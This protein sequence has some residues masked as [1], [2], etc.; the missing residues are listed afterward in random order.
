MYL[1]KNLGAN[2][3]KQIVIGLPGVEYIEYIAK[4]RSRVKLIARKKKLF[5]KKKLSIF[6]KITR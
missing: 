2:L 6:E 3:K 1:K 4:N 5:N